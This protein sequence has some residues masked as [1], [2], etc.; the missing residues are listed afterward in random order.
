M[1][2]GTFRHC[3]TFPYIILYFEEY[4][5][6]MQWSPVISTS[7]YLEP[8]VFS[9]LRPGPRHLRK[10][11]TVGSPQISRKTRHFEPN[12]LSPEKISHIFYK[13]RK[14]KNSNE[15]FLWLHRSKKN[16]TFFKLQS[17]PY[18]KV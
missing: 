15:V 2:I 6:H 10:F 14:S 16:P 13:L 12:L 5:G 8:P 7:G 18:K 17:L 3:Q 1:S 9:N 4:S 11:I